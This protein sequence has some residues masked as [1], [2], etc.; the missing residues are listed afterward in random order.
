MHNT[1]C[2]HC[3]LVNFASSDTCKRC[4]KDISD[5]VDVVGSSQPAPVQESSVRIASDHPV[6]A[7]ALTAVFMMS[8]VGTSLV[9]SNHTGSNAA[10]A[11]GELCGSLIAWP[12]V[13]MIVY[14]ISKRFREKYSFHAVIN[15]GL[16]INMVVGS[17]MMT[18]YK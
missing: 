3:G 12:A 5:V 4:K 9:R 17:M 6:A 7:W 13:L 15:Y 2:P 1:K 18:G 16:A 10:R 14:G 8:I 11:F